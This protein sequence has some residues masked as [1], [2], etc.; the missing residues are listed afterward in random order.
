[1]ENPTI[2]TAKESAS[3][4]GVK[5]NSGIVGGRSLAMHK[6]IMKRTIG[7]KGGKKNKAELL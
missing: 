6:K 7:G 4:R 2:A 1:M 3:K 5:E